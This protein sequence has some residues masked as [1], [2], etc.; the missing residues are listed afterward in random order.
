MKLKVIIAARGG[1]KRIPGKNIKLLKNKPLRELFGVNSR[2][3]AMNYS[4]EKS[5]KDLISVFEDVLS[6]CLV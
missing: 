6:K 1:S 4:W 5:S 3:H 2:L